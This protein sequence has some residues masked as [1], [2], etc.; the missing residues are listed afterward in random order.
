MAAEHWQELPRLVR[1]NILTKEQA[2]GIVLGTNSY[3]R[4][5]LELQSLCQEE[6]SKGNDTIPVQRLLGIV[7][8]VQMLETPTF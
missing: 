5:M 1:K 7:A 8:R 3:N 2:A 6:T 4:L